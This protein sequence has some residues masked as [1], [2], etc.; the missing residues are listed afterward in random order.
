MQNLNK[1]MK[2]SLN[3]I[4]FSIQNNTKIHF[5]FLR[6]IFEINLF[7]HFYPPVLVPGRSLRYILDKVTQWH[8]YITSKEVIQTQKTSNFMNRLKSAIF[9]IFQNGLEWLCPVSAALKNPSQE[10]KNN[11]VKSLFLFCFV[12][13]TYSKIHG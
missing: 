6:S 12:T 2:L 3:Y 7:I 9:A 13:L 11:S 4:F 5:E 10:F 1:R 8:F